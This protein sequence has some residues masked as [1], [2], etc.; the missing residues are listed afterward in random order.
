[1]AALRST[2][3]HRNQQSNHVAVRLCSSVSRLAA[4]NA[5]ASL[6]Y[7][8]DAFQISVYT[9]FHHSLFMYLT[10]HIASVRYDVCHSGT[11]SF[12]SAELA[13]NSE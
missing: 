11:F 8:I 2:L 6:E 1:M 3:A 10:F 13:S 7:F 4:A 9:W 5:V 12:S